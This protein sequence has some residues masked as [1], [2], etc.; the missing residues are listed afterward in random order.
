MAP[1]KGQHCQGF[2]NSFKAWPLF[3]ERHLPQ[4]TEPVSSKL[5]KRALYHPQSPTSTAG[6]RQ[7]FYL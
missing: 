2:L 1:A 6:L 7:F 3:T 4:R 5:L